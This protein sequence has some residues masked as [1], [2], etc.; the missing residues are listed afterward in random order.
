MDFSEFNKE[1]LKKAQKAKNAI[2]QTLAMKLETEALRFVDDNFN[3]QAW[4][5]IAW[6]K[7]GDGTILVKSGDLRR[8][9]Y[10]EQKGSEIHIKNQIPYA[11]AHNEGFEGTV[12]VPAHKRAVLS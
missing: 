10:A 1:L 6:E 4:E 7:S 5:G 3:N 2:N 11:K 8:G 12:N 9:F